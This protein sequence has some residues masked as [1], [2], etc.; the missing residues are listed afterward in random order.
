[1]RKSKS[2]LQAERSDIEARIEQLRSE[3]TYR[4]GVRLDLAAA[5]GTASKKSQNDYKYGRLRAG[6]NK[7]LP[8]GKASEYVRLEDIANVQAEIDR[9]K[10]IEQLQRRLSKLDQMLRSPNSH[11]TI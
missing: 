1:M 8:N 2:D 10:A 4:V 11:P 7:L 6:R 3:G 9:G 5:A